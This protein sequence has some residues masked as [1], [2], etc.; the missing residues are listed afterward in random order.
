MG[1]GERGFLNLKVEKY[2]IVEVKITSLLVR[3]H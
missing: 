2:A 1:K 3:G